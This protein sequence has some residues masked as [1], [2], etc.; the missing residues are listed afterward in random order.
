MHEKNDDIKIIP[1]HPKYRSSYKTLNTEWLNTYF[2]IEPADEQILSHPEQEILNN[3]GYIFFAVSNEKP[4]GT[5][6]LMKHD[7]HTFEL[8][9]MCVSPRYQGLGI[10]EELLDK[11]IT[12]A[13]EKGAHIITLQTNSVLTAAMNLYRKK[14]FKETTTIHPS[15]QK[16]FRRQSTHMILDLTSQE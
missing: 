4:I 9:K 11:V 8:S 5:C 12:F 14:G 13:Q 2:S 1:Y 3:N 6:T 16:T 10:G 15:S 7:D